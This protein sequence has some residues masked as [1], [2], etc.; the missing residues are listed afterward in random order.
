[1]IERDRLPAGPGHRRGV[2]QSRHPHFL[3]NAGR[4]AFEELLPGFADDVIAGGG[5]IL[6]P[7]RDAAYLEPRGWAPR[8]DGPLS[9]LYTSRIL[10]ESVL[11]TRVRALPNVRIREQTD[12][13]G[14]VVNPASGRVA[15]ARICDRRGETPVDAIAEADLVVDAMGRG[16]RVAAWLQQAT[17]VQVPTLDLNAKVMYSSRWY[18]RP[19]DPG[20]DLWWR[21]LVITPRPAGRGSPYSEYLTT[22]Y[23]VDGDR[24]IVFMGSWGHDMPATPEDFDRAARLLRTPVFADAL[25]RAEPISDVYTTRSTHNRWLRYDR[26]TPPAG[27]LAVGDAACAF[28]PLYG[29]GLSAAAKAATLLQQAA[30][31]HGRI[32]Q[33]FARS[34][35]ARHERFLQ[36]PWTLATMRDKSYAHA[37]GSEA[38][39]DGVAKRLLV[40]VTIPIFDLVSAASREEPVVAEAFAKVF[41]IEEHVSTLGRPR[42]LLALLRYKVRDLFGRSRLPRPGDPM[43]PPPA[44]VWSTPGQA[45]AT[46]AT[47]MTR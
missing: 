14:V 39:R 47:V 27:I 11:R 17:G 5:E 34:Y 6:D 9:M 26:A 15:G 22:I 21:Q 43:L 18:N 42:F 38:M 36:L 23:P 25:A 8:K 31:E 13:T 45:L 41:N 33:T 28:N 16:S 35:F 44:T 1:M 46:A 4:A 7:A 19:K 20:A 30:R 40:K 2:P 12:V 10:L 29:Q 3:L 37:T 32:D 24:W